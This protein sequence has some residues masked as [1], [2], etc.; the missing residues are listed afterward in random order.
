[1]MGQCSI[2]ATSMDRAVTADYGGLV[3]VEID[4]PLR[5]IISVCAECARTINAAWVRA[6][7]AACIPE[8]PPTPEGGRTA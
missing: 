7:R 4:G 3:R 1:M 8:Q 6:A 2:C 5:R